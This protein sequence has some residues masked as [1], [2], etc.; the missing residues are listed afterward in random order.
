MI[1]ANYYEVEEIVVC[2]YCGSEQETFDYGACCGETSAHFQT[3][4]VYQDEIYLENEIELV[5]STWDTIQNETRYFIRFG[6]KNHIRNFKYRFRKRLTKAYDGTYPNESFL[7]RLRV[8]TGFQWTKLDCLILK[9]LHEFPLY[10]TS[11]MEILK[12]RKRNIKNL[13][14]QW[15]QGES[16]G[17]NLYPRITDSE[18][19]I[20]LAEIEKESQNDNN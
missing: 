7:R 8:R 3:G 18:R 19:D 17:V 16:L 5:R 2:P 14:K 9:Q 1:K 15:S 10:Y 12:T 4:Y 11:P 20:A 13:V 6:F